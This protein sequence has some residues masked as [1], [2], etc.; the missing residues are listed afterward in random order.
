M[1][2]DVLVDVNQTTTPMI[3]ARQVT[4]LQVRKQKVRGVRAPEPK[5]QMVELMGKMQ[6][7]HAR[8][9]QT[10]ATTVKMKMDVVVDVGVAEG[11][12]RGA[13]EDVEYR[14]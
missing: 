13:V 4:T 10:P 6:R 8:T 1:D 5:D 14:H 7:I 11:V 2:V 9:A 12:A 3:A